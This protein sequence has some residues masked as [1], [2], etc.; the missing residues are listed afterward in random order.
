MTPFET[1]RRVAAR[2]DFPLV[3]EPEWFLRR[4]NINLDAFLLTAATGGRALLQRISPMVFSEPDRVVANMTRAIESQRDARDRGALPPAWR[5]PDLIPARDGGFIVRDEGTWRLMTF[6]EGTTSEKRLSAMDRPAALRAARECGRGLALYLDGTAAL[7][8]ADLKPSLP[9]Y[10]DAGIYL[11]QFDAAVAGL[12]SEDA[13]SLDL[14]EDPGVR[15]SCAPHYAVAL[16]PGDHAD[17]LRDPEV[18]SAVAFARDHRALLTELRDLRT[19]GL[20]PDRAIHGDTKLENFLFDAGP[21]PTAGDAVAL[22][23]LDTVMAHTWLVDW[24]D[25]A[26]SLCN[27]AG[28]AEPDRGRITVDERVYAEAAEGLL[29]T[30]A[31]ATER[32]KALMP[33]A[34]ASIALE[35]GVRFLADWLRGDT[36][37]ALGPGDPPDLNRTRALAQ[38]T[39]AERLLAHLPRAERLVGGSV[40][41]VPG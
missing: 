31:T 6:L 5:V 18:K 3:G 22:V 12:R 19:A 9:G 2:F 29:T 14:P 8:P 7:D 21:G 15:A 25:M 34:A 20:I 26:R 39:L 36:Y 23:D 38:L 27:V 30:M 41:A 40:A 1:A 13:E 35:L 11:A 28:E 33:R 10:R 37:F 16:A 24:G 17:R 4:G 32:E